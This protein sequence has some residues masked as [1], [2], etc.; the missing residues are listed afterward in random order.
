[1][2]DPFGPQRATRSPAASVRSRPP[3]ISR[4]PKRRQSESTTRTGPPGAPEHLVSRPTP[5]ASARHSSRR[6][7]HRRRRTLR[8]GADRLVM[9]ARV[10]SSPAGENPPSLTAFRPHPDVL[11]RRIDDHIV[12]VH[13]GRNEIFSLNPTGARLWSSSSR[14]G[15]VTRPSAVS[16]TSSTS[17]RRWR[18]WRPTSSRRSLAEAGRVRRG[19]R[20]SRRRPLAAR[21]LDALS[22]RFVI[23]AGRRRA[24]SCAPERNVRR[25]GM[26]RQPQRAPQAD[27][28]ETRSRFAAR[29]GSRRAW[30]RRRHE[31]L[32]E[33]GELR[34]HPGEPEGTTR[35]PRQPVA[36]HRRADVE[37][38]G[39]EEA[40][41]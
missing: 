34:A 38:P 24:S 1:M 31:G 16:S 35:V 3:R 15:H 25:N 19:G 9:A 22:G 7:P 26:A 32:G 41:A 17:Q 29:A 12:L 20:R 4:E 30:A 33:K 6:V 39:R 37:R 11:T 27:E 5:S 8:T 21:R 13:M 18:V 36:R 2:P 10:P 14:A 23:V 28:Y 40:Q